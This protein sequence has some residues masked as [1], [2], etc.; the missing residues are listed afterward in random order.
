MLYHYLIYLQVY[1]I[2]TFSTYRCL[3]SSPDLFTSVRHH[4]LLYLPMSFIFTWSIYKCT[5]SLAAL[6]IDVLY[7]HLI[8]L[9]VYTIITFSVYC[10]TS[11]NFTWCIC[12][13]V[14]CGYVRVPR[15]L[16]HQHLPP[17]QAGV[18]RRPRLQPA[19]L[20]AG[21]AWSLIR[22][23]GARLSSR[24]D[25]WPLLLLACPLEHC[26]EYCWRK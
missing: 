2:I 20:S 23:T 8:Y 4:Y 12:C 24:L 21:V 13:Q 10:C 6:F 17:G 25:A 18:R 7:L 1:A 14:F 5:P 16:P 15:H 9:Q 22:C 19:G 3:L 26:L 11:P